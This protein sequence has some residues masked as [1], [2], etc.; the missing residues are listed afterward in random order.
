M[1]ADTEQAKLLEVRP[2]LAVSHGPCLLL[3]SLRRSLGNPPPERYL[4]SLTEVYV[5]EAHVGRDPGALGWDSGRAISRNAE[6]VRMFPGRPCH[7]L[8]RQVLT[9]GDSVGTT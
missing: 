5:Q 9:R 1:T 4:P 7:L 8:P 2:V 3:S 6:K